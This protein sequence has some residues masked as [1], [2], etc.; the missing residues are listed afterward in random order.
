[1]L[2]KSRQFL[3]SEQPCRSWKAAQKTCGCGQHRH[4]GGH[5][6]RALNERSVNDGGN[7]C[8]LWLVILKCIWDSV[9]VIQTAVGCS[10][11]HFA[12]CCALKRTGTFASERKVMCSFFFPDTNSP[13][14]R[15][16]AWRSTANSA[17]SAVNEA[18]GAEQGSL[19]A[20]L[21]IF[22]VCVQ[23]LDAKRWLVNFNYSWRN[24]SFQFRW[25]QKWKWRKAEM[26]FFA[27]L[28]TIY[29][30]I[31]SLGCNWSPNSVMLSSVYLRKTWDDTLLTRPPVQYRY[32]RRRT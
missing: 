7:L 8:P 14:N 13:A 10:E 5:S 29:Q 3:S 15:L 20:S 22:N 9:A 23:I 11:L 25:R 28:V 17:R 32:L 18:R 26:Q 4:V 6:I 24:L 12:R 16:P 1:M 21:R 2:E 30:I 19:H 31:W 27:R